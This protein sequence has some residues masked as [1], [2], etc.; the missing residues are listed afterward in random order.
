MVE[1]KDLI[2]STKSRKTMCTDGRK[3]TRVEQSLA[4]F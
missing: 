1:R 3:G 4:M 2:F